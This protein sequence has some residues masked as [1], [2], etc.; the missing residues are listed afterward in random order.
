MNYIL[1]FNN[2]MTDQEITEYALDNNIT[3][4]K[5]F[6]AFEKVYL[7]S[8][9]VEPSVSESLI[10]CINDDDNPISLLSFSVDLTDQPDLESI[11]TIEEEKDWWKVASIANLDFDQETYKHPVKGDKCTVYVL[12]S[13]IEHTHTE[14]INND[15]VQLL[16]S[17]TSDFTDTNG[18]GTALASVIAG[19][20]CSLTNTNLK[21]VKIFDNS[22]ATKQSDLVEALNAIMNDYYANNKVSSVVNISWTIPYNEYINNKIQYMIDNG[23]LVV[24]SSGNSGKPIADVTPACIPDAIT[25]G[26]YG[27]NL[28]PSNF[29]NYT[30][31]SFISF[32]ANENNYGEIDGWAPGELIWAAVLNGNYGYTAG[33]SIS[34]AIA[35]S[36]LAYNLT[37][38]LNIDTTDVPA[39]VESTW[40]NTP[41][42]ETIKSQL[43]F[44]RTDMMQLEGNYV[45][46]ANKIATFIS[47][48]RIVNTANVYK[49]Q[50]NTRYITLYAPTAEYTNVYTE[51]LLPDYITITNTGY[52]EVNYPSITESYIILPDINFI[53]TDKEGNTKSNTV[54][55][56]IY[57]QDKT[58]SQV[59]DDATLNE[60]DQLLEILLLSCFWNGSSCEGSC[61]EGFTCTEAKSECYC[62]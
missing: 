50:A 47:S 42:L 37:L 11:V 54:K 4:L 22:I 33:T 62:L 23:M 48:S 7:A 29:S 1:D 27:Q 60:N 28:M 12:D 26:S 59:V 17:F 46:S 39:L 30:D 36:V 32:T 8:C 15:R 31:P 35:S 41:R 6:N 38:Y 53:I 51:E 58:Y 34:S 2:Q 13:G 24:C 52:M 45:N 43:L 55:I 20:T 44:K 9:D 18:H 5:Q 3:L 61:K 56:V 40:K 25:V 10:S 49:I 14:F 16:H 21:I 19:N 57:N